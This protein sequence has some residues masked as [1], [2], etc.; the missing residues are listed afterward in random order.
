MQPRWIGVNN[1]DAL[2]H[3][4]TSI[5][6]LDKTVGEMEALTSASGAAGNLFDNDANALPSLGYRTS[7]NGRY[8][9]ST[10]LAK[11]FASNKSKL[12]PLQGVS[13]EQAE[14]IC[15]AYE[16]EIGYEKDASFTASVGSFNK[17]LMRRTEGI[18]ANAPPKMIDDTTA[19]EIEDGTYETDPVTSGS[20][21]RSA[22]NSYSRNVTNFGGRSDNG[23]EPMTPLMA[24]TRT[25]GTNRPAFFTGSSYHDPSGD[26]YNTQSCQG[27]YGIQDIMGNL[28]EYS[29]EHIFCDFSGENLYY[30]AGGT[31]SIAS[32]KIVD[33]NSTYE[34]D[35]S[36]VF[37]WVDSDPSTGRCSMAEYGAARNAANSPYVSNVMLP[38]YDAFGNRNTDIL[39]TPE[40]SDKDFM[41]DY[42][43]GDGYFLDFGQGRIMAPLSIRDTISLNEWGSGTILNSRSLQGSDPREARYFNPVIGM[44]LS[45]DGGSCDSAADNKAIT[46]SRF[47]TDFSLDPTAYEIPDFPIRESEFL[48]MGMSE[49]VDQTLYSLPTILD[50]DYDYISSLTPNGSG[51]G[52]FNY[53]TI[54]LTTNTPLIIRRTYFEMRRGAT[55]VSGLYMTNFGNSESSQRVGRYTGLL[56]QEGVRNQMGVQKSTGFRCVVK[57]DENTY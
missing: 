11:I 13:Q 8:D 18:V 14:T 25:S 37:P 17:R 48:S 55:N 12:P 34:Y 23:G 54:N 20:S 30:G 2:T 49:K 46:T 40:F 39:L 57:F 1:L 45:C 15:N 27:R 21:F 7:Y 28:G 52:T 19:G 9:S 36:T 5:N 16:V 35:S 51:G 56:Q 38:V 3:D 32:S 24:D 44:G 22:C 41:S 50:R 42:R 47:V 10:P 29:S 53:S 31:G 43:N 33:D 6:L 4:S 26:V